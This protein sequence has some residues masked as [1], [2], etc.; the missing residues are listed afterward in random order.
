MP[1]FL[2]L[3]NLYEDS[4]AYAYNSDQHIGKVFKSK[5]KGLNRVKV[6]EFKPKE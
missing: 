2:I 4:I 1:D 6:V 5:R 3:K